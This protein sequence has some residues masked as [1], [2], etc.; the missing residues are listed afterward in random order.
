MAREAIQLSVSDKLAPH[1]N[2]QMEVDAFQG[3]HLDAYRLFPFQRTVVAS[4]LLSDGFL[5]G[6]PEG[7]VSPKLP[8]FGHMETKG[9]VKVICKN[10]VEVK[11]VAFDGYQFHIDRT[12]EEKSGERMRCCPSTSK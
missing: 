10:C 9:S 8:A 12:V 11:Q 4:V 6:T 5:S 3:V 2:W 1:R 7:I